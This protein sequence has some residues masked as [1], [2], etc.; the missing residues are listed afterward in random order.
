MACRITWL[1]CRGNPA[2]GT[3][4]HW[5]FC[6]YNASPCFSLIRFETNG[7]A[8]WFKAVGKP[9]LREFP[10]T[11]KLAELLPRFMPE[12]LGTKPEWNGWLSRE[13]KG[14]NLGEAKDIA[15]WEK[16]ATDLAKLQIESISRSDSILVSGAHDLRTDKLLNS[17]D[18]F[19]ELVARLME[20]QPKVPP[21]TLGRQE[22]SLLKLRIEDSLTLLEDLRIPSTL[23]HLDLNPA[24]VVVSDEGCILLDWAEAYVGTPFFSTEY[25]LQHF[26]CE[27]GANTTLESQLV[28]AYKAPW[29]QLLS[30]DLIREA[31]TLAP[32]AAVFAYVAGIDVWKD[33]ER[34]RDPKIGAYFRSLARRMNREAIQFIE[35]R[36]TCLS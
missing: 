35:R 12:I 14:R 1:D 23:G 10:I 28:E 22:L 24:N 19:L 34:L 20:K 8:V 3:Q 21:P 25:L 9:N 17:I 30:D 16:A 11:L 29:R 2:V 31:L 7:P 13:V 15:L 36:S 6:Q 33:E 26:R 27:V 18:P 32:L 5:P 4:T